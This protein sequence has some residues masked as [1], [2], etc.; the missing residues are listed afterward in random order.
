MPRRARVGAFARRA[1]VRL[2]LRLR[3]TFEL[4][5]RPHPFARGGGVDRRHLVLLQHILRL[6]QLL[7]GGVPVL[8]FDVGFDLL[9]RNKFLNL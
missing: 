4:V 3:V 6:G 8:W 5:S 1:T 7:L 9:M 2:R